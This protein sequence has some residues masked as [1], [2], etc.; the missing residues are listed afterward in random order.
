MFLWVALNE[1]A[2]RAEILWT[3]TEMF[4][5]RISA[6][7]KEKLPCSGKLGAD[8]FSWSMEGHAKKCLERHCELANKTP[9]QL[10]KV[11]TPCLDDHQIN[12][13]ELA[14][15]GESSKHMLSHCLEMPV[16]S[17]IL[18]SVNKRA[19]A[20][21]KWTRACDERLVRLISSIHHTSE[22]KQSCHVETLHNNVGWDFFRTLI[23]LEILKTQ[24][25]HQEDSCAYS[26]V[27]HLF[28]QVGCASNKHLSHTVQRMRILF[29]FMQVY[30]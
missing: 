25:Q 19:R 11:A 2:K 4:E 13:E 24:N 7:T 27:I 30:A 14:S 3:I 26:V 21:T 20:I 10:Y 15:A 12:E 8:I 18:W 16:F 28:Q 29:R 23:F 5:S 17:H 1:N 6:G 22:F 9:Q